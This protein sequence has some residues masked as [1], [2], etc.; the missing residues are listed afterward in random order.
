[1]DNDPV[2]T[3]SPERGD[4]QPDWDETYDV[5]VVGAGTGLF[6]AMAAADAGLK[7]L[8]VEKSASFGG[9]AAMSAGIIWMPG[10]AVLQEAATGDTRE[11]A[12][13]YLDHLVGESAPRERRLSFLEH[14]PAAV[15]FLR[16][17]TPLK[18]MHIPGHPDH[19]ED[20]DGASVIG[21]AIEAKPFNMASLGAD[22]KR[23]RASDVKAPVPMPITSVDYKW[24]V[25]LGRAPWQAVPHAVWRL[26]Q[27]LGGKLIGRDV[28][29]AGQA[30]VAGLLTGVREAEV[31]TWRTSPLLDL[32]TEGDGI[33]GAVVERGGCRIRVRAGRGVILAGGGF[34]NNPVMRR[35][36]QSVALQDGW[37]VNARE[38]TG[39]VIRIA[40]RHGAALSAMDQSWWSLGL[41]PVKEGGTPTFMLAER[42]QP[43]S[44]IVDA[45]GRRFFNE[46]CDH[47]TAGQIMLGQR[48]ADAVHVPSWL[49]FDQKY[50][51][52]H[53]F[54]GQFL[55]GLPL[56]RSWYRAGLAHRA[57]T[58]EALAEQLSMPGLVE[59]VA[60]FNLLAARGHDDDFGRG[61]SAHDRYWG[62]PTNTPNPNLRP[63]TT[64]PFHAVQVVPGDFGTCGG[65]TTDG[66]GRAL[67]G[68]GSVIDGLYA[69]GNC[70]ANAFGNTSP[71]FGAT[72]GLGLTF[73]WVAARHAASQPVDA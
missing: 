61:D 17:S 29:A 10:N 34:E 56:P 16:R 47:M 63:L 20:L 2:D 31:D 7:V 26:I 69:I 67:R 72:L 60:R 11:S 42:S 4:V 40:E 1:M 36:Y 15:D 30:L 25:L 24:L 28:V 49:V 13:S 53:I 18:F 71:Q 12:E 23:V 55:P 57:A 48:G 35:K 33:T 64:A 19:H 65:I 27:G 51:N 52:R 14:A 68:D 59:G 21:R 8:L 54:G 73:G 43:G 45:T 32:V 66:Y 46:S 38:N 5:V 9:S 70:A 37:S 44:I 58:V 22:R 6:A 3:G 39:D 41:P 50:R 62:D